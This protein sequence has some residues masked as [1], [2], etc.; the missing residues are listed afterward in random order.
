[1]EQVVSFNASE[2]GWV[3]ELVSP[4]T[5]RCSSWMLLPAEN[6]WSMGVRTVLY[7]LAMLYVFMGIAIASDVFMCAIE[8]ITSKKKTVV[9]W[10]EEKQE[11]VE[12]EVK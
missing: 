9:R 1:M 5:E 10:D 3:V 7:V 6:L 4:G 12:K 2:R 11:R 8:V